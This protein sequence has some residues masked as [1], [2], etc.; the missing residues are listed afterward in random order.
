MDK[1]DAMCEIF[2]CSRSD[3][4]EDKEDSSPLNTTV[5]TDQEQIHLDKYRSLDTSGKETIDFLLERE[6]VRKKEKDD[7][8]DRIRELE[9]SA[10]TLIEFPAGGM[11]KTRS[12]SYAGKN[13]AAGTAVDSFS[14]ILEG[15]VEVADTPESRRADFAIGVNGDSMEPVYYDGDVVLVKKT[16]SIRHGEVG[17]FQKGNEIYM[18]QCT[19]NGLHSFNPAYPDMLDEEEVLCLGRVIGRAEA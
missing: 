17:I 13:A 5:L 3:L 1:V 15:T 14:A 19:E 9:S 10:N 4:I 8:E 6:A 11:R 18:K 7:R 2:H 12:M 16:A